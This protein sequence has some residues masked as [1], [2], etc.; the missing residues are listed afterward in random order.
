MLRT[1]MAWNIRL[2]NVIIKVSVKALARSVMA[3]WLIFKKSW[4][5]KVLPIFLKMPYLGKW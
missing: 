2:Q 4:K 5:L 3:N 1:S